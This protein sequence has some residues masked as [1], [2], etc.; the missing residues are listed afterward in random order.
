MKK[1]LLEKIFDIRSNNTN[2]STL[3]DDSDSKEFLNSL[4]DGIKRYS[5]FLQKS[6]LIPGYFNTH[7]TFKIEDD[8]NTIELLGDININTR[9]NIVDS[10]N[11]ETKPLGIGIYVPRKV[12]DFYEY[13]KDSV[14]E[15]LKNILYKPFVRCIEK[16]VVTGTY[17][18]KP[19][20]STT[21]TITGT[22]DFDGLLQ[23]VR[24]LKNTTDDGCIIGN[25]SV[26][27]EIIDTI[28]KDSY[29]NEYLLNKTIEGVP[30]IG[31]KDY[32]DDVDNKFLVGFDPNK[33]CLLL[34]PQLQVKKI[35]QTNSIDYFFQI[36]GFVN[37]GD[38]FNTSTGLTE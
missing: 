4:I 14:E 9:N 15:T 29:L 33:I 2:P 11:C 19:L 24:E 7:Y 8:S 1:K 26:I 17:F 16:N 12:Y 10:W 28:D 38:I 18:D 30:I 23:L 25:T 6:Q 37:G 35:S 27:N 13:Y 21:N 20:F 3:I 32:P 34:I 36:F 31:S 5:K 22:K